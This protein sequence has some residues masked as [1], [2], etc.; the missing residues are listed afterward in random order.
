[1]PESEGVIMIIQRH[2]RQLFHCLFGIDDAIF[3]GV[4]DIAGGIF[5]ADM[6]NSASEAMQQRN[7]AWEREQLQNKHQWEVEDLRKAGLNPILSATNGSSAVSAGTPQ[8]ANP[9]IQLSKTLEAISH[10][11]LMKKQEEVQDFQNQTERIKAEADMLRAKQEEAKTAS[12]IGVNESTSRLQVKQTEMLDKNYELQ[13]AYTAANVREID[14][15]IINSVAEVK[16]KIQY[17]RDSGRAAL[18]SASAAQV[19]AQAALQ[20]ASSQAIIAEVARQN[21]ISQIQL[22][23]ALEGKAS[24]ETKEAWQRTQNL[25]QSYSIKG[26]QLEKD[27]AHN[28]IA[29]GRGNIVNSQNFLFGL[30]EVITNGWNPSSLTP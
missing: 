8:G 30:G 20:N 25:L 3:G 18:M 24:Q 21:G 1:M 7:I 6:Q 11:S 15:R 17:L 5:G 16:A 2:K 12:A 23:A 14:Q 4:L 28:P 22:N 29:A 10:S 9:N 13:K 26:W 27:K 19:S